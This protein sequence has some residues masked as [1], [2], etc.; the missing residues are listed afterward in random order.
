MPSRSDDA[1]R[2]LDHPVN[3]RQ[4]LG[5]GGGL[6]AA[7]LI[8]RGRISA[9]T[10]SA[11]APVS[12][13]AASGGLEEQ[14]LRVFLFSGP[15]NDAHKRLAPQFTEYTQ[16]KVK[17][18]VEDG[19]RDVDYTTKRLAALQ[20]GSDAYD[21]IH[22]DANDFL[23]LGSAGYFAALDDFMA[24]T[25]LFD[26]AAYNLK[27]FPDSLLGLFQNGGKQYELPQEASTLMFFYRTDMLEKYGV[28]PPPVTGY[29]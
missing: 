17:V 16:G 21:V 15:E 27:D 14:E 29:S 9:Q 20:A 18:T 1:V 8:G 22:A 11:G 4:A 24:D 25:T 28:T 12:P 7:G 10:P 26:P 5:I 2:P 13:L 3:R 6:A 19:G 23:Q